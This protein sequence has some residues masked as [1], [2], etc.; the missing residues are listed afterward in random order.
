M[1]HALYIG[2][3]LTF[4][5]FTYLGLVAPHTF[6]QSSNSV[7]AGLNV[8]KIMPH[9]AVLLVNLLDPFGN[10]GAPSEETMENPLQGIGLRHDRSPST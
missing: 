2:A 5:L 1:S 6:Y 4:R 10:R 3:R 7:C 8:L 9:L